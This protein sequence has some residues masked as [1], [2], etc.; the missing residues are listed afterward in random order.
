M[1]NNNNMQELQLEI[2][3]LQNQ[4]ISLLLRNLELEPPMS[5][6]NLGSAVAETLL[7]ESEMCFRCSRIPGVKKE[8]A[9][10]LEKAG[11]ELMAKAV[12]IETALQRDKWKK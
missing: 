9:D 10:R 2:E 1:P 5:R 12:E 7:E 8:V 3:R 6:S 4:V 11:N